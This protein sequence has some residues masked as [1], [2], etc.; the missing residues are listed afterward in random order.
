MAEDVGQGIKT[1]TRCGWTDKLDLIGRATA[2]SGPGVQLWLKYSS[3]WLVFTCTR[4][5]FRYLG[6][7]RYIYLCT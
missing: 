1:L 4:S 7:R 3:S 5:D 2:Q 6:T